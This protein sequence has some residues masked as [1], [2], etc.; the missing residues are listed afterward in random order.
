[1]AQVREKAG[2]PCNRETML[3]ILPV[4]VV[5]N[6]STA[7][8]LTEVLNSTV[9]QFSDQRPVCQIDVLELEAVSADFCT[10]IHSQVLNSVDL[11]RTESI[12][13]HLLRVIDHLK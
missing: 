4:N 5:A 13:T 11:Y 7:L 1:M 8:D 9:I 3:Y 10:G 6:L 2:H 12:I